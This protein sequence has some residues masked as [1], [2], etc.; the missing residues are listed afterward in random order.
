SRAFSSPNGAHTTAVCTAPLPPGFRSQDVAQARMQ[1]VAQARVQDVAQG[2]SPAI[3][4][5]THIDCVPPFFPSRVDG[6]RV[7]GRGACDA[8]IG[9][10]HLNSS[11]LVISYA[12]FC[13]KK[14]NT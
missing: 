14:K 5:S 9:R 11:H 1:D 3:V 13:L 7:F 6:D 12:V 2:F 4:F 10:A 8:K